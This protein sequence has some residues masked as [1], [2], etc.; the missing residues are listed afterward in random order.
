MRRLPSS[1]KKPNEGT[2]QVNSTE[3]A[4]VGDAHHS[5]MPARSLNLFASTLPF[6]RTPRCGPATRAS[7]FQSWYAVRSG[8]TCTLRKFISI[9]VPT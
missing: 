3:P 4:V 6:V 2:S 9:A 1:L 8:N 5:A 7:V